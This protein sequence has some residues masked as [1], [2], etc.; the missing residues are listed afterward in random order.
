MQG[1]AK[2]GRRQGRQRRKW[3]DSTREWT[4]VR[5]VKTQRAMGNRVN[6]RKLAVEISVVPQQPSRLKGEV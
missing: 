1:T 2:G 5:F 3:K 4:D 6:W